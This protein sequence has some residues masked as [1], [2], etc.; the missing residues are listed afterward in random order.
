MTENS[1][2]GDFFAGFLVGA[3]VG[4]AAALIL[5][6]QSG[7]ETRSLIH[8]RGIELRG[9]AGELSEEARKRA[10]D[11]QTQAKD[12]ASALEA[13]AKERA[14]GIQTQVKHAVEE[15]KTAATKRKEELLSRLQEGRKPGEVDLDDVVAASAE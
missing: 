3:L 8:D 15:G 5:A 9:R 11:L 4:A 10:L 14:A 1:G 7:E 12:R 2:A 6:P 13:Q